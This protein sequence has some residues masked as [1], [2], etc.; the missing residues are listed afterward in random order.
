[1][2]L[3]AQE[4]LGVDPD[5][6]PSPW[7]AAVSSFLAFSIGA[8]VPLITFFAGVDQLWAALTVSGVALFAAGVLVARLTGRP[9]WYGGVRQL[10]LAALA[11]GVTYVVGRAIGASV[12]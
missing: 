1:L 11:A 4:E 9:A 7:V 6:L 12:S 3:H 5:E 2:R 8:L 10:A